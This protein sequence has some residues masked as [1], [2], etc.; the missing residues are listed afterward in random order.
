MTTEA[1]VDGREISSELAGSQRAP[2]PG[3]TRQ[4]PTPRETPLTVTLKLRRRAELSHDPSEDRPMSR[5]ELAESF[6]ADPADMTAV[7]TAFEALGLTV[8][9]ANLAT[10][11]LTLSGS[12]GAMERAFGV[13][14][15]D[16]AHPSGAYR[17]R[18]GAVRLPPSVG[19][20]VVGVFGLDNRKVAR[21]RHRAHAH[22]GGD[23]GG[24]VAAPLTPAQLTARYS[25][26]PGDG[27]G[28]TVGLLEFG[29][30]FAPADLTQ[31]CDLAGLGATPEVLVIGVA[32]A[33]TDRA[34]GAEGEVMLDSEV[35]AGACPKARQVIYFADWTEQG[36]LAALDAAI[37]DKANDPGVLSI[38]WG[39]PED[40]DIWT[41]QAMQQVNECLK[42]A[43]AL[44]VTVC[45]ATGDD[46]SS[47]GVKDGL[48]HVD[49]PA[50]SPFA[51]A[52]GGT[53]IP[54][55]AAQGVASGPD[56]AWKQG[57]GL[58]ADNG[59]S[60]GGGVS[61]VFPRP[62]WQAG[63]A[64]APVNP[65][66]LA[67]RCLPDL[68]VN[69]DWTNS[70]YLTVVDGVAKPGGGTSAAAP[71]VA[72]LITRINAARATAGKARVGCLTPNLYTAADGGRP[73]GQAVCVDVVDGDNITAPGGGYTAGLGYD[74]VSGWG[75]PDGQSLAAALP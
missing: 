23:A 25:F 29:G 40:A 24:A 53:T 35:I 11:S 43:A 30:R 17:G 69:A 68:A 18:T 46:G 51:L 26:P 8:S 56:R 45:V 55:E 1:P 49:F 39:A 31:F 27:A 58:R 64:V 62:A 7:R 13:E 74:A 72:A 71:L 12:A 34:D 9:D 52:V 5:D 67:G 19:D 54:T 50:S 59:G 66:G 70:P 2:L 15:S 41:T 48:A 22:N 3:A 33:S 36:W 37:Q 20:R 57:D 4:G 10:R 42:D 28:Q 6:G 38:S 16:Y 65:G 75:T 61:N 44:G 32:G 21:R 73:M 14:L 47:D 63:I 60:S